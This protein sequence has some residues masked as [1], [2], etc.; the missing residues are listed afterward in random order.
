MKS[1][2]IWTIIIAIMF[3]S[4][5]SYA[6]QFEDVEI[7]VIRPRFFNKAKRIE[8]GVELT[9]IMN[10]TFIYTFLAT[11]L[12]SYHFSESWAVEGSF[13]LGQNIEKE[14]KRVLFDD[15]EIKTQI[16]RTSYTTEAAL[17]YTPIYGK[18]QLASGRL[19]YF[20]S[21]V[22]VGGGLTAI[23]WQ[24]SDFCEAPDA[25]GEPLPTDTTK[26][27]FTFMAG[28]GQRYFVSK[29]QAY[30]LDFRFHR[31]TYNPL[32]AECSPEQVQS[33]GTLA[34]SASHDNL[35]LRFGTSFFF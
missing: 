31:F 19:I 9:T 12:A 30:K 24:Y 34:A 18:W 33:S 28:I 8:L 26:S 10:E 20:D 7:R 22:E 6:E 11:G 21:Y 4:S 32:D 15:F 5:T 13:S 2:P 1:S 27:Y 35:T 29:N 23:N 17:Q 14:D 3:A 16:F 25:D